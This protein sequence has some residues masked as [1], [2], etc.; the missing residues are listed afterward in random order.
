ML[1]NDR[2]TKAVPGTEPS[3]LSRRRFVVSALS[4]VPA[5]RSA[6]LLARG[7]DYAQAPAQSKKKILVGAHLWVYAATQP[8]YD[9]TPV[10]EDVF[11]DVS[12]A[13]LDCLELMHVALRHED[14]VPRIGALIRKYKLPIIG[15]S[16]EGQMWNREKH[17]AI[18]ADA[19]T[20]VSRIA[21]LGGRTLGVSVGA[22]PKPKTDEQLD[23]QADLLRRIMALC[24]RH[25]VVLNLHNHTYEVE[26]GEHDLKGTLARIPDIKLGPDLNWL[27]RAGVDPVDFILR[28]GDRIVFLHLRDQKP[29]GKW[30]EAMGEGSMDYVAIGK[31]LRK[32]NLAGDAMIELAFENGFKP[33]R[34][35]RETWR[36]S[37]EY[38]RATMGF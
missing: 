28:H 20:V 9:P 10:L 21:A 3:R 25:S 18:Y 19:E 22:A 30:S 4:T 29:D 12:A 13:G 14:A 1:M 35:L 6:V 23:A 27:V 8:G 32:I 7:N 26:N 2:F 5:A 31:A 34:P 17:A 33:T 36:M 24:G 37:R 11:A 15:T 16:F 38:V